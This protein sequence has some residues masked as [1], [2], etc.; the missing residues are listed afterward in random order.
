MELSHRIEAFA[1][2]GKVLKNQSRAEKEQWARQAYSFNKW[3]T[4]ENVFLALEGLQK[5]LDK[6]ALQQWVKKYKL[7]DRP[8][9][10]VGLVMAGNIPLV[11]FHDFLSVLIAGY[12]VAIKKSSQ[13]PFLIEQ[14][15]REL[16]EIAPDFVSR[17]RFTEKLNTVD[18]LIA[19]GSD[20][21]SRYFEYYFSSIPHII[22]KNRSSAAILSGSESVEDLNQ[23]GNDVFR[24]FGLGCRNV[25][26][27]FLPEGYDL[28]RL[29]EAF[30]SFSSIIDHSKYA[31]NYDYNKA[32]YLLK[33]IPFSDA[34]FF[35]LKEDTE[36]VSPVATIYYEFYKDRREL[37]GLILGCENK[38]QILLS[39]TDW[40]ENGVRF[41]SS[42]LPEL[43]DYADEVDTLAFLE[44]I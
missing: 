21:S 33:Q 31:N 10:T 43:N 1:A 11:G 44:K 24:Y 34:G 41:G 20:N 3:F 4:E 18:A 39:Q 7:P 35:L 26:K 19:T 27:L 13:D 17:I 25:S 6:E 5:F 14:I 32:I 12:S 38:L 15:A 2:L 29:I 23:L 36:L 28:H 16:T 9:K 30:R 22:R 40:P 8:E 37:E 42:Q